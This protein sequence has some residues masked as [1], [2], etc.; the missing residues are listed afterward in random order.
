MEKT[1]ERAGHSHEI[2]EVFVNNLKM[3][4]KM[5]THLF[6]SFLIAYLLLVFFYFYTFDFYTKSVAI[7][8][9][10]AKITAKYKPNKLLSFPNQN[11]K[12]IL[13]RASTIKSNSKIKQIAEK[14]FKWRH[15]PEVTMQLFLH[16]GGN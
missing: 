3:N 9:T 2:Y 13:L 16:E 8:Y 11:G 6:I 5:F 12:T 14:P 15:C 7:V 4:F 10:K 1:K